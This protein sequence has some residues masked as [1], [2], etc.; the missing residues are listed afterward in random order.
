MPELA[1][2][3]IFQLSRLS[4][5]CYVKTVKKYPLYLNRTDFMKILSVPKDYCESHNNFIKNFSKNYKLYG[6]YIS[7]NFGF[8]L[9]FKDTKRLFLYP[10]SL[11]PYTVKNFG[12]VFR[13][14]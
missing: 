8:R 12:Q 5:N 6:V 14:I 7:L 3:G 9:A 1:Q 2:Q 13:A 11:V 10:E 4:V